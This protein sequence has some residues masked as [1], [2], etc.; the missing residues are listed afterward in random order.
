MLGIDDANPHESRDLKFLNEKILELDFSKK[1]KFNEVIKEIKKFIQQ[2]I[3]KQ[4]KMQVVQIGLCHTHFFYR[5]STN[6][7]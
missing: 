2:N 6:L 1:T 5:E 7:E 3:V 4:E